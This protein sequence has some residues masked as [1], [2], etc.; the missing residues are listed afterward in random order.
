VV[1]TASVVDDVI[2]EFSDPLGNGSTPE[3]SEGRTPHV[4]SGRVA[5]T[6]INTAEDKAMRAIQRR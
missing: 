1:R 6:C 3:K 5:S 2:Q 4:G